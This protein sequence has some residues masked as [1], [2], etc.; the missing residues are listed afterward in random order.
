MTL[1]PLNAIDPRGPS[2]PD[3]SR[4]ARRLEHF[5]C[6]PRR[7]NRDPEPVDTHVMRAML[8]RLKNLKQVWSPEDQ[9]QFWGLA[10]LS[11]EQNG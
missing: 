9:R 2:P 5:A 7:L 11:L 10:G 6:A 8:G 3:R 4:V 1:R